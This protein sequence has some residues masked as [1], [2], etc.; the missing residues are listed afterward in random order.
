MNEFLED[1]IRRS[2]IHESEEDVEY[3]YWSSDHNALTTLNISNSLHNKCRSL[4]LLPEKYHISILDGGA[5]TCVLGQGWEILSI[6][7]SRRANVVGFDHETA[8]KRNL[9]IVSAITTVDLP[10]GSSILLVVHEGIYNETAKHSLLSEFQLREFGIVI[11]STCHRHGGA[12]Q[13]VIQDDNNTVV[14]PLE[15]AGCMIHF[16]HRLPTH[17]ELA[18]LK[19][20]CLTQ[21]DTPWKPSSF[22][23]QVADKYYQ[24]IHDNE[25]KN[26]LNTTSD[27]SSNIKIESIRQVIPKLSYFDPYDT[28]QESGKGKLANLVLH[29]DTGNMT[30][31]NDIVHANR[32]MLDGTGAPENLWFLSQDYL[33]H[34]HSLSSSRQLNWKIPEQV[35]RGGTPDISHIP[36]FYWFEPVL[37]LDPVSKFPETTERPG[38]FVGFA[39]NVGDALTFKT[40]KKDMITV[41]HRSVVRSAA[42]ANQRNKQVLLKSDVQDSLNLLDKN[43]SFAFKTIHPKFKSRKVHDDVSTRTRSKADYTNQ[44]VGSRTRTKMQSMCNSTVQNF[45]HPLHDAILFQGHGKFQNN[46]F[47]LGVLECKAY[48]NVLMDSKSQIDF[49]GLRQIHELDMAENDSDMSWECSKVLEHCEE[50]GAD[51]STNHKS[52]VEWNDINKSQS[53]V[54]FFTPTISFARNNNFMYKMPFCHLIEYCKSK[55]SVDISGTQKVSAK[56]TSIKYKFGIQVP[57]GIKNAIELDKKNGNSLCQDAIKTDL[58]QLIDYQTSIVLDSG[59]DILTGYQKIPNHM[60][61]VVKY[62]LSHKA[63]VVADDNWTVNK[64]RNESFHYLVRKLSNE[65]LGKLGNIC[66]IKKAKKIMIKEREKKEY[67][68]LGMCEMKKM[69]IYIKKKKRLK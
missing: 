57:K 42:D 51:R 69:H 43:S 64:R 30:E 4:L 37:Y 6:H 28:H 45:L 55:S 56:P 67:E 7:N 5:D 1:A 15:L 53:W 12:Q 23:E 62:D 58:K 8:V 29:T 13:M 10:D 20:Y 16:K 48:N 61:L 65:N 11:D 66:Y 3:E 60:F 14:V 41:L 34:V 24:Q 44:N 46:D 31:I 33:T 2:S 50:R 27:V 54:N 40:L 38:C 9:P 18:S 49:D 47:Q 39:D 36:M 59:E 35:S 63:S 68:T 21:G 19:Q 32:V 22:S 26:S 25:E 52:L 17:E